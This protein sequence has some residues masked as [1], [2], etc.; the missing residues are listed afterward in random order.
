MATLVKWHAVPSAS[1]GAHHRLESENK[2]NL[3]EELLAGVPG[4]A[5]LIDAQRRQGLSQLHLVSEQVKRLSNLIGPFPLPSHPAAKF[6]VIEFS[7][8]D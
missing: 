6:G 2:R 4:S 7:S 8:A 3:E 1:A 5:K